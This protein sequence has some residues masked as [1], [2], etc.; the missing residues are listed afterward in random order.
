MKVKEIMDS[1]GLRNRE[2][3]V[4]VYLSPAIAKGFVRMLYPDSPRSP[5]QRYLLTVK[6]LSLYD[7][8]KNEKK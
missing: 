5:K 2:N 3:F 8:L 4:N 1:M 7:A 6:G